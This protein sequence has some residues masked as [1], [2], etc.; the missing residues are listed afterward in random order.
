MFLLREGD[1]W[2]PE[3]SSLSS[4]LLLCAGLS[5]VIVV[6][7]SCV[8]ALPHPVCW[9][10][11]L[12]CIRPPS[13]LHLPSLLVVVVLILIHPCCPSLLSILIVH[14]RRPHRLSSSSV[15]IVVLICCRPLS[16]II[17]RCPP[18]RCPRLSSSS[19]ILVIARSFFC[20]VP[21]Q[22][23]LEKHN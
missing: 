5:L 8:P 4:P 6:P 12:V 20:L 2:C 10:S 7:G 21:H 16:S 15:L 3:V 18:P 23:L 9:L 17:V 22:D 11:P 13:R 14:P 1:I 19:V